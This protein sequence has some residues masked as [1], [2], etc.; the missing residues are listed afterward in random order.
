MPTQL[1]FSVITD[2]TRD[3]NLTDFGKQTL[4]DR[5]LLPGESYQDIF[6]RVSSAYADDQAHAQRLYDY[7]SRLWFMPATPVLANGG[8]NRALPVSCFVLSVPDTITGII[9]SWAESALLGARGGG[10]GV[11]YGNVRSIGEHVGT[12][13]GQ[14][15]GVIPF[16]KVQDSLSLAISQGNVRRSAAAAYL[17][18][19]HP[20]IEEFIEIRKPTG[21]DPNRRSLNLHH[22]VIISDEF[23]RAVEGD[24]DWALVSPRDGRTIKTVRARDL[25]IKI[26]TMRIEQGE[27]Y[28]MFSDT[29]N[30]NRSETY[31]R[32][33]HH[34]ETSQLCNEIFL[35]TG[36]DQHGVHRTAICCL[37]SLNLEKY[38]EWVDDK[39]FIEDVMRFLD[40]VLQDFIDRSDDTLK[41]SRYSAM[42]ERSVGLGV[43]GFHTF[44]QS[45]G[46]PFESPSAMAWNKK[47]FK[48]IRAEADA[49]SKTL[50]DERGPCPD[51][52]EA[53]TW[54]RFANKIAIAPTASISII[55]GGASPGIEPN[56]ANVYSAKTL[57]GTHTVRNPY[58]KAV[59]A[60]YGMDTPEVWLDIMVNKGSVQHLDS[61]SGWEKDT[62]KTAIEL[63]QRW[64]VQHGADRQPYIDQGQSLNLFF[65]ADVSKKVLNEVHIQAWKQGLKGLYYCRSLSIQRPETVSQKIESASEKNARNGEECLVCQ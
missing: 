8:T 22:A 39:K 10:L 9:D 6:A 4:K 53:G 32:L 17:P 5:Y 31:T 7:M 27:P 42:R 65:P 52:A 48:H 46:V 47:M 51:S 40:N 18:I 38:S 61:L 13:G 28:L 44:L 41:N 35:K 54:E 58:L 45:K 37:S 26:L 50:A 34:I 59:L 43:M 56:A 30:K 36:T 64:L 25:W 16:M 1:R 12:D 19:S 23:M 49:A 29:V 14:T 3:A 55:C 24:K 21:G 60:K 63:D 15:S 11:Y 2:P 57:S 20:E 33:D 62:F